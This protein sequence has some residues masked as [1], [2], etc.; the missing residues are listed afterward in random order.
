MK[1]KYITPVCNISYMAH[2]PLI[3]AGSTGNTTSQKNDQDVNGDP[4]KAKGNAF[5]DEDED[6]DESS[7]TN[8]NLWK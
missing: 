7:P 8:Y 6:E 3:L 5:F 1:R 2:G 4:Q